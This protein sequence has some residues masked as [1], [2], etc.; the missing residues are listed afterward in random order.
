MHNRS[1]VPSVHE[2]F[3][4]AHAKDAAVDNA[5][6]VAIAPAA[7]KSQAV[8][9]SVAEMQVRFALVALATRRG[10]QRSLSP[11]AGRR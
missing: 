10:V 1:R 4:D 6:G 8:S 2:G 7:H 3:S 9:Y 5:N 11:Q